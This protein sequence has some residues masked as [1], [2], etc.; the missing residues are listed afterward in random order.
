VNLNKEKRKMDKE[1]N[2]DIE[3][4]IDKEKKMDKE[5]KMDV[6]EQKPEVKKQCTRLYNRYK[7]KREDDEDVGDYKIYKKRNDPVYFQYAR[8]LLANDEK[9][10]QRL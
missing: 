4:N 2:I 6:K 1:E 10:L 7:R 5:E 9:S 8:E 3:E